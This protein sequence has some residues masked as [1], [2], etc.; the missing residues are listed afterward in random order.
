MKRVSV[1]QAVEK[2]FSHRTAAGIAGADKK[3]LLF[4]LFGQ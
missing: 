2:I 4:T 1:S 3:Y